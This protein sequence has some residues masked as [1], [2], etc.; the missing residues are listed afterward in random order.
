MFIRQLSYLVALSREKH[1]GRAAQA[2][3]VSQPAL[4]GAIRSIEQELGLVIV[5]RGRR[6][7]ASRR[8]ASGCW[9]GRG[10]R[11]PTA[12]RRGV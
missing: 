4:S 5:Q 10:G 6:S 1:F 8:T 7:R 2:C 11:W 12:K 9:P 3:H